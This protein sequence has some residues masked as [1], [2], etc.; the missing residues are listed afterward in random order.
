MERVTDRGKAAY[1]ICIYLS[2]WLLAGIHSAVGTLQLE[3]AQAFSLD[4]ASTGVPSSVLS[5]LA[6]I[7]FVLSLFIAGRFRKSAALAFGIMLGGAALCLVMPSESY[8]MFVLM[9]GCAGFATGIMDAL[10]SS[11]ISE[12]YPGNG[13]L[14]SLLHAVYGLSGMSMPFVFNLMLKAGN[15]WKSAYL[16]IGIAMLALAG[17]V[18]ALLRV[19]NNVLEAPPDASERISFKLIKEVGAVR[20]LHPLI[21]SMLLGGMYLNV[22]LVRAKGFIVLGHAGEKY[23]AW[24]V[25]V[26][27]LGITLCRLLLSAI[28]PDM[29]RV[30]KRLTPFSALAL[31]LAIIIK[32]P[33]ASLIMCFVSVFCYAPCIPFTLTL[34]GQL[35]AKRRFVVTVALMLALMLGQ[36]I[37]SPVYGWAEA[38][39]GADKAMLTALVCIIACWVCLMFI[40]NNDNKA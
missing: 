32:D 31:L 33:L 19:Y 39:F 27:Y 3:M 34:A 26:I 15:S 13:R 1:S 21:I 40:K 16:M 17:I 5:F 37:I 9:L 36:A 7:A 20:E 8:Y 25:S 12:L 35:Y 22:M 18:C 4:G 28:N 2:M 11:V 30:L 23:S 24:V 6:T 38:A 14:M 10:N 29:R